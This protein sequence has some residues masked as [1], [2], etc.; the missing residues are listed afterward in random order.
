MALLI[1][2][3]SLNNRIEYIFQHI[4]ENILGISIAFT[5][6]ETQFNQFTGPKISY[7]NHDIGGFLNYRQHPFILEQ[8]IKEQHLAFADYRSY[9]IPF[10]T[11]NSVFPFDVF[12]ASFYLLSRY[13]EY[14]HKERDEH[15]RFEGKSSLAYQHGFL[16][17]PVIDE[18]AYEI[19]AQIRKHYPDFMA[20]ERKFLLRPTLDIDRPYYYLNDPYLKQKVKKIKYQ[21]KSDP[22]DIYYQVANWDQKYGLKTV[23]FFLLG[24]QHEND[25]APS[26]ENQLFRKLIKDISENHPVGIHP[27]YYAHLKDAEVKRERNLIIKISQRKISISRQHYLLLSLPK[28]YRDLISAGIKEDYTMAYADVTGFRAGTCT[29]FFWYDLEKEQ[30]FDLLLHPTTAMDQTLRRYMGLTPDEALKEIKE[31][32]Q[33]VKNVNGDFISL[34]HNESIGDFAH[35]KGWQTVYVEMLEM[36]SGN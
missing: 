12:A 8:N 16:K 9:K 1:Y 19:V 29:P 6:N 3:S 5:K 26:T 7:C 32:M 11:P 14:I 28:T 4:F 13:E 30:A 36:G 18:W 33:N 25:T 17:H 22:F 20:Q 27:S 31:L 35:W 2:I 15:G 34:W 21:L 10:K 23:Y 24:N